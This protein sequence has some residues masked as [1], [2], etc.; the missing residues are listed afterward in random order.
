MNRC[1]IFSA[2]PVSSCEYLAD[3]ITDEDF[4]ICADGGMRH[5]KAIN[6]VPQL[7][8]GDFDSGKELLFDGVEVIRHSVRKDDTD[9]MLAVQEGLKRGYRSFLLFGALGGRLDH[10]FANIMLLEYLKKHGAQG[11]I[12][13]EKNTLMLISNEKIRLEK[14]PG[15]KFSVFP[16][17]GSAHGI[18]I[19]NAEYPVSGFEMQTMNPSGVSNEFTQGDAVV[20][21]EDGM[22]LIC[23][24]KD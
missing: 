13:E 8:V 9:T 14:V 7:I 11:K 23:I 1:V 6:R 17:G 24:S 22:L 4:L 18:S 15:C 5:A 16:W 3:M 21:V 12:C 2:G 19:Q 20:S 10:T